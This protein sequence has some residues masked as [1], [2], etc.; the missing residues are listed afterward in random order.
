ME[1][2]FVIEPCYPFRPFLLLLLC[3]NSKN[4]FIIKKQSTGYIRKHSTYWKICQQ[5][6]HCNFVIQLLP[7]FH[8]QVHPQLPES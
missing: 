1:R 3:P 2:R 8:K 7:F 5:R 6:D 4:G